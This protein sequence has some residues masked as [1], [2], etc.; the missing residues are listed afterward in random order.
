MIL[1]CGS[2][3][4]DLVVRT[5]HFPAPGETV[6][7][8]SF[9]M[10]PGGKGANQA[11]AASKLGARVEFLGKLGED[12]FAKVVLQSLDDAGVGTALCWTSLEPTGVA[13]I[14]LDAG[15]QNQIIVSPGANADLHPGDVRRAIAELE[16]VP[17]GCLCQLE[18]PLK[19]V[20]AFFL[21]CQSRDVEWRILNPAP[22]CELPDL[23][24]RTVNVITP[25]ESEASA[26]TGIDLSESGAL[27]PAATWFHEKGVEHVAI[28]LG[29]QGVFVSGPEGMEAIP[30]K[31]VDVV[32]TTAAG[33]CFSGALAVG[34]SEGADFAEACYFAVRAATL[35]VT[36]SGAQASMPSRSELR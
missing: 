1:V 14:A 24:Y 9:A 31:A 7:G 4:L 2:A 10:H 23:L 29:E 6:L 5:P 12:E 26:L 35:S 3:N 11:V 19:S 16:T 32:D 25:N 34:L 36:R 8:S 17:T 27:A 33:D 20:S 13:M 30:A 28:T 22:A 21:E 15:G 18:I